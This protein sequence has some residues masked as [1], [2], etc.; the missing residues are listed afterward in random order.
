MDMKEEYRAKFDI[1]IK[2]FKLY[3]LKKTQEK[4]LEWE[5]INKCIADVKRDSDKESLVKLELF[6]KQKKQV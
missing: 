3:V 6:Y 2:E 1:I 4:D 5:M